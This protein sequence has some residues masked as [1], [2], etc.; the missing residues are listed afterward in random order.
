MH[1]VRHDSNNDPLQSAIYNTNAAHTP[2][3]QVSSKY[4]QMPKEVRQAIYGMWISFL[5]SMIFST[6][7]LL[8]D[9]AIT[10]TGIAAAVG[11]IAFTV[12]VMNRIALGNNWARFTFLGLVIL[13]YLSLAMYAEGIS[14]LDL[15]SM[16]I[17]APIDVLVIRNLF[18]QSA[19]A[20]FVE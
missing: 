12:Y 1:R 3:T 4:Q 7:Q 5:I 8:T 16:V 13:S 17:T 10:A 14:A 15:V 20:W 9:D 2:M 19:S 6:Y 11:F 18:R